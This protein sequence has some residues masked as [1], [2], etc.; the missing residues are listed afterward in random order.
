MQ[1]VMVLI[2]SA[3]YGTAAMVEGYRYAIGMASL[4]VD[5]TVV[6]LDDGVWAVYP[7]QNPET[8][9]MKSLGEAFGSI[10]DMGVKLLVS[11][12]SLE[13]RGIPEDKILAGRVVDRAGLGEALAGAEGIIQF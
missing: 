11:R 7:G 4:E 3:P 13:E 10:E 6:L 2:P 9:Q 8:L 1:K 12:E 5:T